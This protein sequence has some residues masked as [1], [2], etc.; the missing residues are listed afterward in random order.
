MTYARTLWTDSG[1]RIV[2]KLLEWLA[3]ATD[4]TEHNTKSVLWLMSSMGGQTSSL[5]LSKELGTSL[6]VVESKAVEE[7]EIDW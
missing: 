1:S 5:R 2:V 4:V 3:R 6:H 7:L